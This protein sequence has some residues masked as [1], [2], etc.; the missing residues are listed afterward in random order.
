MVGEVAGEQHGVGAAGQRHHR[1][2]HLAQPGNGILAVPV[3]ADVRIGDLG[4]EERGGHVP[5]ATEG[6]AR[7]GLR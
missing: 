2:D 3:G 6:R 4:D 5:E 7:R 1:L